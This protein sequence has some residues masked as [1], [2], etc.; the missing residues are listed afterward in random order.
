MQT[1]AGSLVYNNQKPTRKRIDSRLE[2]VSL[3]RQRAVV[4]LNA[5]SSHLDPLDR[6]ISLGLVDNQPALTSQELWI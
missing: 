5:Q 4:S 6:G 3:D 2:P 1:L